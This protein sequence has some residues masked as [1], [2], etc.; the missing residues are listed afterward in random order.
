MRRKR[1]AAGFTLLEVLLVLAI[2]VALGAMATVAIS[3]RQE[4]A[5]RDTAKAQVQLFSSQIETYRFDMK[6]M[7]ESL[8]DLIEKPSDSK[9]AERWAG[10]YL[11]KK[12]IPL[13][14]WDNEYKFEAK[15]NVAKV[16]SVGPDGSDGTDDDV[17][18][19]EES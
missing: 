13:D 1:R 19:E 11:N 7:P 15:D 10:P 9:A 2:L 5:D 3:G 4:K 16:W 8:E 17:S 18:S 14:P 6:K 12:S